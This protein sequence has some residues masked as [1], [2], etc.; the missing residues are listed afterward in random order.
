MD[1]AFYDHINWNFL[2]YIKRRQGFE[3][4]WKIWMKTC[5][6]SI[7]FLVLVNVVLAGILK[8]LVPKEGDPLSPLLLVMVTNVFT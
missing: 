4:K 3:G 5:V 6:E 7:F 8:V 2:D 1:K